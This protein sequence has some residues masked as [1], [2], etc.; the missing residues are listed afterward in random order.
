MIQG[1]KNYDNH[2]ALVEEEEQIL[3]RLGAAVLN[4]GI[5]FPRSSNGFDC[6]STR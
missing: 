4:A 2:T 1:K 5:L 3:K 6:A